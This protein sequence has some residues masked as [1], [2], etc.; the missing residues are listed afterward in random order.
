MLFES[1][2][3][4]S[5]INSPN[6]LEGS[7]VFKVLFISGHVLAAFFAIKMKKPSF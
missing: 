6:H 4:H 2:L 5:K 7:V 1:V 3:E